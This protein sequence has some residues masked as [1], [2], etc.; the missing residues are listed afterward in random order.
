MGNPQHFSQE[1][2]Q[3]CQQLIRDLYEHLPDSDGSGLRLKA[4]FLLSI[5]MPMVVLPVE[6]MLKHRNAGPGVHMNDAP[7]DAKLAAEIYR[8]TGKGVTLHQTPFY[9]EDVWEWATLPKGTGFP[10]LAAHGLPVPVAAALDKPTARQAARS[11]EAKHFC[12]MLRNA[13]AHG[14][15]LYLNDEGRT[16]QEA[17][18]RRL[19][20]VSTDRLTNPTSLSFLRIRIQDYRAFLQSWADWLR[21]SGIQRAMGHEVGTQALLPEAEVAPDASSE[22]EA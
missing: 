15:I 9:R 17:P 2:P 1:L 14:G 11:L 12:M 21:N 8:V 4:T 18:V 13:L 20:F 6:R 7:L 22:T 16:E 10:D 3:R 5:S 19:A